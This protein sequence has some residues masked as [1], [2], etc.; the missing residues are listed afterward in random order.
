MKTG[1]V[2]FAMAGALSAGTTGLFTV[3]A[4]SNIFGAGRLTSPEPG[5]ISYEPGLPPPGFLVPSTATMAT[6]ESVT[7][8]TN[9]VRIVPSI[10]PDGGQC[11]GIDT[12]INSYRG[13]SGIVAR[14]RQ[15]FL[16]GVFLGASN[17]TDPAP[18]RISYVTPADYSQTSYSPELNQ[19]FFIGD[20][21]TGT[22]SGTIQTFFVPAG[23]RRLYFGF[24]DTF[25]FGHY[26]P[27]G[28]DPGYYGDNVGALNGTFNFDGLDGTPTPLPIET[29]ET[30]SLV[31][32][33]AG[34]ACLLRRK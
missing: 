5:G 27:P 4:R 33:A 16:V 11:S 20:G 32:V 31:L 24:E 9:C 10:G 19:S 21:L 28:L 25:Y 13:I 12:Q 14:E 8:L 1:F 22:G 3:D 30:S 23:A 17:P 29:P 34:L 26:W 18:N 15:L 2:C 7:G 6:F